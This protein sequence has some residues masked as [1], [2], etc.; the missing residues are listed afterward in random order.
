VFLTWIRVLLKQC[1]GQKRKK[2]EKGKKG[3]KGE[4]YYQQVPEEIVIS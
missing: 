4:G 2:E 3:K 1:Q